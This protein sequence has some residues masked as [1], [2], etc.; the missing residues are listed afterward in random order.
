MGRPKKQRW[1]ICLPVVYIA[2]AIDCHLYY[3]TVVEDYLGKTR[4]THIREPDVSPIRNCPT[5]YA[6]NLLGRTKT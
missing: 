3:E 1:D 2:W 5:L 4:L 6:F